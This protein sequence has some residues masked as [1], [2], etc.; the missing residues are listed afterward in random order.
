MRTDV[1]VQIGDPGSIAAAIH[2]GIQVMH[3]I[4]TNQTN[5]GMAGRFHMRGLLALVMAAAFLLPFS[6]DRSAPLRVHPMVL[7]VAAANPTDT[8]AVIVQK[9]SRDAAVEAVVRQLGG[10]ITKNLTIINAFVAEMP[11][12]QIAQLAR[13]PGVRW[14]SAD[15]PV[16]STAC[17]DCMDT[18]NLLNTYV[19]AVGADQVWN[20]APYLQGQGITV[21]VVD[22]GIDGQVD[23]DSANT[24]KQSRIV[25]AERFNN[26]GKK[27]KDAFGHGSH[28]A[29][30]IGANGVESQG[31]YIGIAPKVNLVDV[32]VTDDVGRST[33]SDVIAGLEWINANREAYNIR[34]VNLSLNGS[35]LQSYHVSPLAAATE[36]LWFNGIVVVVS[37]GNNG[38]ANLYPPANDPFVI[39]V[40][41]VNDQGTTTLGDDLVATFSAYGTTEEGFTKPDLIAPGRNII[42][43]NA[44]SKSVLTRKHGGNVVNTGHG[45]FFRMSGT[46]VAAPI[47]SGAVALLLQDEPELTPDQVKYRLKATA[48]RSWPGYDPV[49][50]GAG[51][52]DIPA[53]VYGTTTESANTG[54]AVSNLLT[55][56]PNGVLSPSVNWSSVNWSSVNW[57]SVNWSSVNWSSVNWSSVNWSSDHWDDE[58][59]GASGVQE[60]GAQ[61]GVD[62]NSATPSANGASTAPVGK[63]QTNIIYLPLISR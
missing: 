56:G 42:S 54:I 26:N 10:T 58:T 18:T 61:T 43:L 44:K 31:R 8:I 16:V 32:K 24:K 40:G 21:A 15:A 2:W 45:N 5:K 50:A 3:L 51:Y 36:I 41:A 60:P 12:Q 23:L 38:T 30:I 57:S 59:V 19:Q 6:S 33:E 39:T 11:T 27:K 9:N 25:A 14:I 4:Q 13:V 62:G 47:V 49:K 55:T 1:S 29:G 46:S 17:S 35:V 20:T 22:S 53:A 37:A 52:L 34:V 63:E 48:N 7:Q 28:I